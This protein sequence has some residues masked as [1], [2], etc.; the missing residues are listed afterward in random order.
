M[1][2]YHTKKGNKMNKTDKVVLFS[3]FG[4]FMTE[5]II[6]YSIGKSEKDKKFKITLPPVESVLKI[7][8]VVGVFSIAN[9]LIIK[10]LSK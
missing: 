4:L 7:A 6:H 10:K 8:A 5:A 1:Y 2:I 3:T 9:Q